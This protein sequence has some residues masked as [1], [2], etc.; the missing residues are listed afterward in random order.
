[1]DNKNRQARGNFLE[2]M[3]ALNRLEGLLEE[4]SRLIKNDQIKDLPAVFKSIQEIQAIYENASRNM[5]VIAV[6]D[7]GINRQYPE[8]NYISDEQ[9]MAMAKKLD[10]L[11]KGNDGLVVELNNA[12]DRLKGQ[13]EGVNK[14]LQI[15]QTYR[16]MLKYYKFHRID[17][18]G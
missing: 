4:Q 2:A 12:M 16:N 1:M 7:H 18:F 9:R 15:I 5:S 11:K 10:E 6:N 8:S 3:E 17:R 14:G 13:L